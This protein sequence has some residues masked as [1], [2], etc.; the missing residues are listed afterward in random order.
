MQNFD[1][2][3]P[4]LYKTFSNHFMMGNIMAVH[5]LKDADLTK[6]FKHHYNAITVEND[7]KPLYIAP[8]PGSFDFEKADELVAWA[9]EN[10][11]KMIGH[12]LVWH[13]QSP[14]WL[15]QNP[16]GTPVTR[17]EAKRN[18]ELFIKTYAG[19]YS[20]RIHSWDVINEV[21]RDEGGD[22]KGTWRDLLRRETDNVRAVGHWYL[23]YANGADKDLG[24]CPGDYIFDAFYFARKYDPH[25]I[26]Y[27]NEYNEEYPAKRNAMAEM[28]E[29]INEEWKKH[30]DYDG[31]LLIEGIG[32]QGHCNHNTDINNIRQSLQRFIETGAIIAVTELDITFGSSESPARPLTPEQ[33]EKQAKMYE[34]LYSLY[35]EHSDHIER[36]TIW[37]KNDRQSWRAWGSPTLF[38]EKSEAKDSFNRVVALV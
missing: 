23:A 12:T 33:N 11:I 19:R 1:L 34:E 30:P 20:G 3:K 10:D 18:M 8:G 2:T 36:I 37:G 24:E 14:A 35:K 32:M 13:G 6:M 31:R 15:N 26:L 28:V 5:E 22:F 21:F 9:M 16:D 7:M 38:G 29:D 25:A 4:S 27:C 17:G